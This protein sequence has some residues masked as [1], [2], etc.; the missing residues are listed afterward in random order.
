[1]SM[2]LKLFQLENIKSVYLA[3]GKTILIFI[4]TQ[5]RQHCACIQ[6]LLAF[7]I[8]SLMALLVLWLLHQ[9]DPPDLTQPS[10]VKR[11]KKRLPSAGDAEAQCQESSVVLSKIA[12][13]DLAAAL[14][15]NMHLIT[16]LLLGQ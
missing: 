6:R 11:L 1:M 8:P 4:T 16:P 12:R 13:I 10:C 3:R 15:V 9:K 14:F 7:I 2:P 5:H